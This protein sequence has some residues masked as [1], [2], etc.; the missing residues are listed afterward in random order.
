MKPIHSQRVLG[1]VVGADGEKINFPGQ[2]ISQHDGGRHFD[3]DPQ[4]DRRRV[5]LL[6]NL[7]GDGAC[8]L[9]I[10]ERRDHR[11][12]DVDA[13]IGGGSIDGPQ[14]GEEQVGTHQAKTNPAYPQEGIIF[15]G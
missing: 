8:P 7:F 6:P 15:M 11:E 1:Q 14:L 5:Q 10:F 3:H 2:V 12:H 4:R 13:A 9:H